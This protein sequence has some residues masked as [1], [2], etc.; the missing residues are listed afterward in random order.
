MA[1]NNVFL[2]GFPLGLQQEKRDGSFDVIIY[3]F[4]M[5]IFFAWG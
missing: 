3:F 1:R 2:F 4:V 5:S